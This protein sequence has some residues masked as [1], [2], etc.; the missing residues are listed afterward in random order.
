ME[1]EVAFLKTEGEKKKKKTKVHTTNMTTS[2]NT[3]AC[4]GI[5]AFGNIRDKGIKRAKSIDV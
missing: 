3:F 2:H 4:I 1:K 5:W